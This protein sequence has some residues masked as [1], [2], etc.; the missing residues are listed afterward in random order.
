MRKVKTEK[1]PRKVLTGT[2]AYNRLARL[3]GN[4]IRNGRE[5]IGYTRR[6][7]GQA[8]EFKHLY[9]PEKCIYQWEKGLAL[10]FVYNL[11]CIVRFFRARGYDISFDEL[12]GE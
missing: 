12:L 2:R 8:R 7:M 1:K 3:V 4:N 10:P 6:D 9:T 5:Y 11:C